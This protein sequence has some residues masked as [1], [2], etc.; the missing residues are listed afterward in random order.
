MC[1]CLEG[2][3]ASWRRETHVIKGLGEALK[4]EGGKKCETSQ[5]FVVIFPTIMY[6]V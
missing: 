3:S 6:E 1:R 4:A 2:K 5:L